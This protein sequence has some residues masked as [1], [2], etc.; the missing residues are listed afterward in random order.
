MWGKLQTHRDKKNDAEVLAIAAAGAP[1]DVMAMF[2]ESHIEEL[3]DLC[4]EKLAEAVDKRASDTPYRRES[5]NWKDLA[6][7]ARI[8]LK[9]RKSN[10]RICE[11]TGCSDGFGSCGTVGGTDFLCACRTDEVPLALS[12]G[13]MDNETLTRILSARFITCNEQTRKGSKGC[14]KECK[15]YELQEPGMTCRDSVLLH[16]EEAKK[17]LKIRSHNS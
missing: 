6:A 14:T 10:G 8:E 9:R 4:V 17:I 1:L 11:N 3:P 16:A 5:E 15:L 2:F 12:G 7:W 13:M